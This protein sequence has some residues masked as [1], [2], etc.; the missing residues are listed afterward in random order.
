MSHISFPSME[1]QLQNS[2]FRNNPENFHLCE[3]YLL[4]KLEE[5]GAQWLS[6]RLLDSRQRCRGFEPHP[7]SLCYG[8]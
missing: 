6:G 4:P 5:V 3:S 1:S 7:A 2:D 8:P